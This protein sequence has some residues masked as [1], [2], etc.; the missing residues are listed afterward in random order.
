MRDELNPETFGNTK[1]S[2]KEQLPTIESFSKLILS[3]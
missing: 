2:Y 3:P 1:E